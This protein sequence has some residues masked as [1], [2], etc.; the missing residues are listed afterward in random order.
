MYQQKKANLIIH[1][2]IKY[3][4]FPQ[5]GVGRCRVTRHGGHRRRRRGD[6]LPLH[7]TR[8]AQSDPP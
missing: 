1:G 6:L 3:L 2:R 8:Q 7:A 4:I 5:R